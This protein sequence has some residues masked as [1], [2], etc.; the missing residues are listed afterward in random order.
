MLL[1]KRPETEQALENL[2]KIIPEVKHAR[3]DN[4]KLL[5]VEDDPSNILVES[6]FLEQ[7]GYSY[8]VVSNGSEVFQKVAA[9]S[10]ALILMN[11][12]LP[13]MDGLMVTRKLRE[14]ERQGLINHVPIV[15]VTAHAVTGYR[16]KCLEAG[17]NGYIF[18]PFTQ[19]QLCQTIEQSV[20]RQPPQL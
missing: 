19:Q 17:M 12:S 3:P 13:D 16:E 15:A 6:I 20:N 14:M 2:K 1:E 18:K 11:I 9:T 8:D 5:L 10:Y 4:E 7:C